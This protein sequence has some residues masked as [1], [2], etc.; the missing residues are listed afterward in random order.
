M[1]VDDRTDEEKAAGRAKVR[2]WL[3][4]LPPNLKRIYEDAKRLDPKWKL[5]ARAAAEDVE[6]GTR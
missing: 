3:D 4:N 2:A 1:V 5:Q 6:G